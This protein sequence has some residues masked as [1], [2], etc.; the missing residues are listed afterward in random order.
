MRVTLGLMQGIPLDKIGQDK[1]YSTNT[2]VTKVEYE[3]GQFRICYI[4]DYSHLPDELINVATPYSSLGLSYRFLAPQAD[5]SIEG[6]PAPVDRTV[7]TWIGGY[8]KDTP[9]SLMQ[10]LPTRRDDPGEIGYYFI[11]PSFRGYHLGI[12]PVGQAVDLLRKCGVSSLRMRLVTDEMRAYFPKFDFIHV[13][14]DIW[15]LP[16]LPIPAL[17][18]Y[19]R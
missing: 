7:G 19:A 3:D 4:Y 13:E 11:A 12:Q 16:I 1:Q 2:A 14:G 9:V 8:I 10:L 6:L 5:F 18:M 15:E 17:D